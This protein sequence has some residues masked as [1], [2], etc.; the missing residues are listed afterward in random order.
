MGSP[1][2]IT[3]QEPGIQNS[4]YISVITLSSLVLEYGSNEN[5]PRVNAAMER[6]A[7]EDLATPYN[8]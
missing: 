7:C 1:A 8:I 6:I 4:L 3:F 2:V 5:R